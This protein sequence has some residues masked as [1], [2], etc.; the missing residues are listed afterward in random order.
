MLSSATEPTTSRDMRLPLFNGENQ[1]IIR[2]SEEYARKAT[3]GRRGHA[4]AIIGASIRDFHPRLIHASCYP[5]SH[6][7]R[8]RP[9]LHL[10]PQQRTGGTK[11]EQ[12]QQQGDAALLGS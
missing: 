1:W 8:R 7:S 9:S 4:P 10:L 11:C 3:E 2:Q 5:D 6:H 12:G